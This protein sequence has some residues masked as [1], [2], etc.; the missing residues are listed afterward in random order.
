M[1]KISEFIKSR[2]IAYFIAAASLVCGLITF[3]VYLAAGT[4]NFAT[5]HSPT[6]IVPLA[7]GIL[8]GAFSMVKTFKLA[9]LCQYLAYLYAFISVFIVNINLIANLAYNIDGSRF[10]SE[11]FVIAAFGLIA[12][13][14]ALV[15]GIMTKYGQGGAKLQKEEQ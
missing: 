12:T 11:F 10:P 13:V 4:N 5:S 8:I 14:A 1:N 15:S 3:T 2:S 6:V 7:I 9:L